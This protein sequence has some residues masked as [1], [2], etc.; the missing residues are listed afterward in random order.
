MK[1]VLY[2]GDASGY[3]KWY[4]QSPFLIDFKEF[5]TVNVGKPLIEAIESTGEFKVEHMPSWV[6]Y[7]KFPRTAEEMKKYDVILLSDVEAEVLVFYPEFY[8]PWRWEG[9][10]VKGP[11]RVK[12]LVKYVREGGALIYAG[13]WVTFNGRFY[14]GL[15]RRTAITEI[16]PVEIINEVD[17]RVECP[18]GAYIKVKEPD[19]PIMAGIPWNECPPFLGYNEV[20]AKPGSEVLATISPEGEEREDPLIVVG[21]AGEGRVMVFAT[22]PVPHW[23][24]NFFRWKHYP[25]FWVQAVEWLTKEA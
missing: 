2:V 9:K 1:K 3:I 18:E 20:K 16:L 19:H 21:E 17:D 10:I 6:A 13:S 25:K 4:F 23:G 22:D 14:R 5:G 7:E 15:W 12:E 8:E 11:N 24:I